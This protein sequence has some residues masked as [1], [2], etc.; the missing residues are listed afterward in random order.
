[1]VVSHV[2]EKLAKFL[3]HRLLL[4]DKRRSVE[5]EH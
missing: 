5:D 1:M 3:K 2:L 4:L